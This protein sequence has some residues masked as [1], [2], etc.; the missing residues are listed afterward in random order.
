MFSKPGKAKIRTNPNEIKNWAKIRHKSVM[1][2]V[3]RFHGI[4]AQF[5]TMLEKKILASVI[6]IQ[7]ENWV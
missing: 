6:E 7:K 2:S 5:K 3:L 1:L 4:F